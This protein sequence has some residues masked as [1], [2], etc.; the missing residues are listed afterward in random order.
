MGFAVTALGVESLLL[1]IPVGRLEP[2]PA[3]VPGLT[4]I[5]YL[6][7]AALTAIGI[8]ILI[9]KWARLAA[10]ALAIMLLIW[11]V[12][13]YGPLLAAR[14]PVAWLGTFETFA[15]FNGAWMLAALL[16]TESR[17]RRWNALI[18]QGTRLG[19]FGFGISLPV[20]GLAHF[21]YPDFVASW[22][23]KWLPWPL[24]WAYFTGVAHIA[25]GVAILANLIARLAALLAAIMYGSWV[26]IVHIPR[27][28]AAPHDAFEWNGIFVATAL[29]A[30]A[31][32]ASHTYTY[33]PA[34]KLR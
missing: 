12:L 9:D 5:A 1:G 34:Q 33:A 23:P 16:P 3:S 20:F 32:L 15:C 24:F 6:T 31:L 27:T 26:L 25:A 30:S 28:A 11:V 4:A 14:Q 2:I 8:C 22:I 7:G 13:L 19:R 10:A 17:P 29:C 21:I 18:E